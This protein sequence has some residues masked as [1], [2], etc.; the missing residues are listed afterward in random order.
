MPAKE[1]QMYQ[2]RIYILSSSPYFNNYV[3]I[4][5]VWIGHANGWDLWDLSYGFEFLSE[6][7]I[8]L[9]FGFGFVS[10]ILGFLQSHSLSNFTQGN[11]WLHFCIDVRAG[12]VISETW[13]DG[14]AL[15]DLNAHLVRHL[16]TSVSDLN[17]R[18]K[19]DLLNF[20]YIESNKQG[21][22]I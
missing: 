20:F 10:Q 22:L 18:K 12:T 3:P 17:F 13:E 7:L 5:G 2:I 11:N 14:Q 6:T 4:P 15:K 9:G 1:R 21:I 16:Y 8:I 19:L